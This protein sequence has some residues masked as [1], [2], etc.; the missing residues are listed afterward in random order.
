M[1]KNPKVKTRSDRIR[2]IAE[3]PSLLQLLVLVRNHVPFDI[4]VCLSP[5]DREAWVIAC[6]MLDGQTFDWPAWKWRK[7]E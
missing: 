4:A 3:D 6:G 2:A 1:A 5:D 7:P